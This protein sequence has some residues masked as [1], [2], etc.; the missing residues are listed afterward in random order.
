M[1]LKCCLSRGTHQLSMLRHRTF[2]PEKVLD[3]RACIEI[4]GWSNVTATVEGKRV[5][6]GYDGGAA[7]ADRGCNMLRRG[8]GRM[9]PS[10]CMIPCF[11][12]MICWVKTA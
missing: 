8:L 4:P 11:S 6:L 1:A 9:S 12:V 5:G 3:Q 7:G 2:P 10:R